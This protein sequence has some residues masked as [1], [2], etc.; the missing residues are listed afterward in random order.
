[1]KKGDLVIHKHSGRTGTIVCDPYTKLF[2]D[3][4]DWE[5]ASYGHDSATAATA[6]NVCWHSTG[7][8]RVYKYSDLKRNHEVISDSNCEATK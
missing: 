3:D 1:M 4:S 2:R 5:A 8:T 7:A 6:I